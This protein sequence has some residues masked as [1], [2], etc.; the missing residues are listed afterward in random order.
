MK[1]VKASKKRLL[2]IKKDLER[3]ISR[4]FSIL[5]QTFNKLNSKV[6]Q[7]MIFKGRS[8]NYTSGPKLKN[9]FGWMLKVGSKL[10]DKFRRREMEVE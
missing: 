7:L 5:I 10:K 9:E 2:K 1:H 6:V 8:K 4:T 3:R